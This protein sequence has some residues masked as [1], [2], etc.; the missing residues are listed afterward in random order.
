ME[1]II[2]TS[3]DGDIIDIIASNTIESERLKKWCTDNHPNTDKLNI[4]CEPI[5]RGT[6]VHSYRNDV[7]FKFGSSEP[8]GRVY[9]YN[10]QLK[11][12]ICRLLRPMYEDEIK[13]V[14]INE[15]TTRGF[16][17][18]RKFRW[19]KDEK[20]C[21]MIL[22]SGIEYLPEQDA[23]IVAVVESEHKNAIYQE[24]SWATA[25][26]DIIPKKALPTSKLELSCAFYDYMRRSISMKEFLDEYEDR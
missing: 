4:W 7:Y 6:W 22:N 19:G 8:D 13:E 1:V 23:L 17:N 9:D 24:G 11:S 14:L 16:C 25:V 18:Y 5:K 26:Y 20:V 15:A 3:E 10:G 12:V 2:R 21:T